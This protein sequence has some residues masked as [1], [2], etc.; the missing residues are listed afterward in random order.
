MHHSLFFALFPPA[1]DAERLAR[2]AAVLRQ[3]EGL[4]GRLLDVTRLHVTL[5][6]L[7]AAE[8]EPLPSFIEAAK[9]AAASIVAP[10][11]ELAFDRALSFPGSGAFVLRGDDGPATSLSLFRKALGEAMAARGI[12]P[13]LGGAPH[14]TLLYDDRHVAEFAIEP[15]RWTAREFVL[16]HSHVGRTRHEWLGRWPLRS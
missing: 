16:V 14:M 2:L 13:R 4:T 15:V 11:F 12:R 7:G 6:A 3:Q 8:T 5:L 1:A 9:E 10:P